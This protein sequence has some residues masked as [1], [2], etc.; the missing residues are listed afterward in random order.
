M[1]NFNLLQNR[2][3]DKIPGLGSIPVIGNLFKSKRYLRNQTEMLIFATP[4][5]VTAA[6]AGADLRDKVTEDFLEFDQIESH[7]PKKKKKP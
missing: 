5:V 7:K 2:G 6:E 3:I 4:R 1:D